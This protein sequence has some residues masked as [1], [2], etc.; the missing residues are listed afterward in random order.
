MK[1]K[2]IVSEALTVYKDSMSLTA[3]IDSMSLIIS[4]FLTESLTDSVIS[5]APLSVCMSS[6]E[7]I[8]TFLIL[9]SML[10]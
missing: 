6:S 5:P 8:C 7:V 3:S 1:K 2:K 4:V 9:S 10:F